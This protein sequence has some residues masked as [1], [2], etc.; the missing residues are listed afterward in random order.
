MGILAK[1][2]VYPESMLEPIPFIRH[3]LLHKE[4]VSQKMSRL[5]ENPLYPDPDYPETT[6]C[7][8]VVFWKR[9][10]GNERTHSL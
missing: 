7:S 3:V 8:V 4:S 5:T 9:K 10:G 6:V 1:N 2:P